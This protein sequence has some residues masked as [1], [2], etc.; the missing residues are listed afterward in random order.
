MVTNHL[1]S[2]AQHAYKNHIHTKTNTAHIDL[3][4]SQRTSLTS[5]LESKIKTVKHFL[6][7]QL[8]E[9]LALEKIL[10][11]GQNDLLLVSKEDFAV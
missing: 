5:F 6:K 4:K 2:L 11:E 7:W 8:P 9:V 10:L 1:S 3:K